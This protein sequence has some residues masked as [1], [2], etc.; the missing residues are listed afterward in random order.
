MKK[1]L[2]ALCF[3][4]FLSLTFNEVQAQFFVK[5]RPTIVVGARPLAPS[6]THI[7]VEPEYVWRNGNYVMVNGYWAEPR[8]G[9]RYVPG[10]WKFKK[11]KGH[12]WMPGVWIRIR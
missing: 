12:S 6:R 4:A 3:V 9:Y 10:H 2:L 11:R 7:W 1:K 8:N 5:I